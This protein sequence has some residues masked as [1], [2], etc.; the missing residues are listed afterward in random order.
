MYNHLQVSESRSRAPSPRWSAL[1]LRSGGFTCGCSQGKGAAGS[2]WPAEAELECRV[3]G[4]R[5][6]S[7]SHNHRCMEVEDL[8]NKF[9]KTALLLQALQMFNFFCY[10]YKLH[11][12]SMFNGI[13]ACLG[14]LPQFYK[15]FNETVAPSSGWISNCTWNGSTST[16]RKG[17]NSLSFTTLHHWS[18]YQNRLRGGK[19]KE[20]KEKE[21][22][23]SHIEVEL[24]SNIKRPALTWS[25]LL[26]Q[27]KNDS[28]A[29]TCITHAFILHH[30]EQRFHE[31]RSQ[32]QG[33]VKGARSSTKETHRGLWNMI[34]KW[35]TPNRGEEKEHS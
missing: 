32:L 28:R 22:L 12:S 25:S 6:V 10:Y 3:G 24:Q 33:S 31:M 13:M 35:W 4:A 19:K 21:K 8:E 9:K 2:S 18:N 7:T 34:N 11:I 29:A 15:R 1:N 16:D 23:Q 27:S 14:Y 26:S 17:C 30:V 20:K 5:T